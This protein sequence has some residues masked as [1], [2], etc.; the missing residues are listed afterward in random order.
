MSEAGQPREV[1]AA[2]V[3][4]TDATLDP[5]RTAG[6]T[7][8]WIR[9]LRGRMRGKR[10]F[11]FLTFYLSLL[12]GILWLTLRTTEGMGGLTAT[13]AMGLGRGIFGGVLMIE[14]LVVIAL[15]PAYTAGAIT[16]EREKQTYDL[17]AVTPIS[18]LSLVIGKLLSGLSYLGL[19]VFASFPIACFAFLFGGIDPIDIVR[20]YIVLVA[21][22]LAIGSIGI[23]CS[24]AMSRTQTATIAALIV[25]AAL[26]VGASA[27]WLGLDSRLAEAGRTERPPQALLLLNPFIAELDVICQ[28]TGEACVAQQA[29]MPRFGAVQAV[30]IDSTGQPVDLGQGQ[31]SSSR[32]SRPAATS[33]RSRCCSTWRSPPSRSSAPRSRSRPRGAGAGGRAGERRR[34]SRRPRPMAEGTGRIV[35]IPASEIPDPGDELATTAEIVDGAAVGVTAAPV[36]THAARPR[37]SALA[38][39]LDPLAW[40]RHRG[41]RREGAP[42]PDAR[43]AGVRDPDGLPAVPRRVRLGV[44]ADRRAGVRRQRACP[45]ARRRSRRR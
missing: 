5:G 44:A 16:S 33:G 27:M 3:A 6:I 23:W 34:S 19:I 1:T 11:I 36:A 35:E 31:G 43:P 15:A 38:G 4:A 26:V 45:A 14:T 2:A 21:A 13:Q 9:E 37:D 29:A 40:L 10:A 28:A 20:G 42:G 17:L 39:P 18:S 22:G 41:G 8:I 12:G 24:A 32:R 25:T 7:A 30:P